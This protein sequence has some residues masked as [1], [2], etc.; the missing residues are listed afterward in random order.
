MDYLPQNARETLEPAPANASII[1]GLGEVSNLEKRSNSFSF[2][3]NL[4]T[5]S[6]VLVPVYDFPGWEVAANEVAIE[7]AYDQFLGRI[8]IQLP[9][10]DHKVTGKFTNTPIRTTG[11]LLTLASL[12]GLV[13]YLKNEK[14]NKILPK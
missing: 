14:F 9:S 2:D 4:D 6:L 13:A 8:T 1:E 12:L 3:A 10:G 7:H 11:N 5:E